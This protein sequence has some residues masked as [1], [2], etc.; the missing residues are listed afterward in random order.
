MV[1]VGFTFR[2]GVDI[3]PPI[4][5]VAF[6]CTCTCCDAGGSTGVDI[7]CNVGMA[8]GGVLLPGMTDAERDGGGG[9]VGLLS[10]G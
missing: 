2:G 3:A 1:L 5:G 7:L 6:C 4:V 10:A 9:M 8:G